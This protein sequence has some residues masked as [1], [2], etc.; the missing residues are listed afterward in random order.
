MN[1][2]FA[3]FLLRRSSGQGFAIAIA[4]GVGLAIMLIGLTM[5]TRSQNDQIKVFHQNSSARSVSVAEAGITFYQ[6]LINDNRPLATY[7]ANNNN[8]SPA[9]EE[10]KTTWETI[11]NDELQGP[12]VCDADAQLLT[13]VQ[14]SAS[15]AWQDLQGD[16]SKGQFRLVSYNFIPNDSSSPNKAPGKGELIVEGRVNQ[17]DTDTSSTATTRLKVTIPVTSPT[18][19]IPGVWLKSGTTGANNGIEADV[20][21]NDC[22]ATV[23][24]VNVQ[25]DYQARQTPWDM[26]SLPPIP[27]T[28]INDLGSI[29]T[30]LT[31]PRVGTDTPVATTINGE[32]VNVYHYK[33]EKITANNVNITITPG[34]QVRF[35]VEGNIEPKGNSNIEHSCDGTDNCKFTNFH[36]YAYGPVGSK[37]CTIGNKKLEAFILAPNYTAGVAG[38]GGGSGGIKGSIWA[39]DWSIGGSCGSNTTNTVVQQTATWEEMALGLESLPPRIAGITAWEKQQVAE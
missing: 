27:T 35:Y 29:T 11:E 7:C 13:K 18:G 15:S 1:P 33:I 12:S 20:F 19:N 4:L 38:A 34:S 32:T 9:C 14:A 25:G 37:I 8:Q 26:P 30:D 6:A 3:L 36:I 17:R 10:G 31:L 5:V 23:S 2:K 39:Y 16:A 22:H 24:E 21:L 28:G